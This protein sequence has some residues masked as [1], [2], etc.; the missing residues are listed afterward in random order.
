MFQERSSSCR[1]STR[2]KVAPETSPT[3]SPPKTNSLSPNHEHQQHSFHF[4]YKSNTKVDP[5]S[6]MDNGFPVS[7]ASARGRSSLRYPSTQKHAL[8][9]RLAPYSLATQMSDLMA[10][11]YS[12]SGHQRA[13]PQVPVTNSC[14]EVN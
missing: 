12:D 5:H 13:A 11:K 1:R 4:D 7:R 8:E 6:P 3:N 10:S 2:K 14:R 9:D